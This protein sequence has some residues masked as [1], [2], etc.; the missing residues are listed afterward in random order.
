MC[1]NLFLLQCRKYEAVCDHSEFHLTRVFT[2]QPLKG[3]YF[4]FQC[5]Y[6]II[7]PKVCWCVGFR[8]FKAAVFC[9]SSPRAL[10]LVSSA[11]QNVK[12]KRLIPYINQISLPLLWCDFCFP[13]LGSIK[14]RKRKVRLCPP[15]LEKLRLKEAF[16]TRQ[17][18]LWPVITYFSV[19]SKKHTRWGSIL[20]FQEVTVLFPL[21]DLLTVTTSCQKRGRV[22]TREQDRD[23]NTDNN[24]SRETRRPVTK[25][26][27][28]WI[29]GFQGGE[30][31]NNFPLLEQRHFRCP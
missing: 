31:W 21:E 27:P 2:V 16:G 10:T 11:A 19:T 1:C 9:V 18:L 4:V 29:P 20:I 14:D 28:A 7:V 26:L 6:R 3:C 23:H 8:G 17:A 5:L 13:P 15:N 12:W 30:F 24:T 25:K 22:T